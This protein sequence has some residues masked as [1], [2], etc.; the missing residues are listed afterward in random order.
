VSL[1][2]HGEEFAHQLAPSVIR[3]AEHEIARLKGV[4]ILAGSAGDSTGRF[5]LVGHPHPLPVA[6]LRQ[7]GLP[8]HDGALLDC[9]GKCP[10]RVCRV[11]DL[12]VT[13]HVLTPI[14]ERTQSD[15]MIDS[16]C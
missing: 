10:G 14:T 11:A 5:L 12:N 3:T 7:Q 4:V 15:P 6:L 8:C 9:R 1:Q 13:P 2:Q 16:S